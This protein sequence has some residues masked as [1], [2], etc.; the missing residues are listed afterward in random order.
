[1][2]AVQIRPGTHVAGFR[3][4]PLWIVGLASIAATFFAAAAQFQKASTEAH[5]SAKWALWTEIAHQLRNWPAGNNYPEALSELPLTYPDGD[6]SDLLHEFAYESK[7]DS[8]LATT[9]NGTPRLARFPVDGRS[10][11]R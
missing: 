8:C 4:G 9:L 5:T 7:G 3:S 10:G 2:E 11:V 6:E 1:M